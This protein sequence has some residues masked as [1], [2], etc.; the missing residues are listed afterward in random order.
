LRRHCRRKSA[1]GSADTESFAD[2]GVR[3]G[4]QKARQSRGLRM[5]ICERKPAAI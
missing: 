1:G 4:L 3:L 2:E 5:Q